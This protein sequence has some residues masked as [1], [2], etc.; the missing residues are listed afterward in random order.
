MPRLIGAWFS[1][2]IVDLCTKGAAESAVHGRRAIGLSP[3]DVA[4]VTLPLFAL[5]LRDELGDARD[6]SVA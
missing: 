5:S 2:P 4:L 3:A 1:G 6:G